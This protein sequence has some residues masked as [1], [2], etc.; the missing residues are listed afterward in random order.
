[1]Q[2][3]LVVG[4]GI[5]GAQVATSMR[6]EGFKGKITIIGEEPF[7]PYERPPLSKLFLTSKDETQLIDCFDSDHYQEN[8]IDLLLGR[9][10]QAVDVT[11]QQVM[12][13]GDE[14]LKY[15]LLVFATGSRAR[16]LNIPGAAAIRTLRTAHD[17]QALR[18]ELEPGQ[19]V[20]CIGAGVIGLELASSACMLGCDVNVITHG[21]DVMNRSLPRNLAGVL[22][23]VHLEQGVNFHFQTEVTQVEKGRLRFRTGATL[24]GDVFIAGVGAERNTELAQAAGIAVRTGIIVDEFG[25]T[26]VPSVYAVGDVAEYFSPRLGKHVTAENWHHAQRH[27]ASVGTGIAGRAVPYDEIPRFWTDQQ[28]I[29]IQVVGNIELGARTIFRGDPDSKRFC[30]FQFDENNIPV[31][32][33]GFDASKD[34]M[35]GARLIERALPTDIHLIAN[36]TVSLKSILK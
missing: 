11:A 35:G 16:R 17:A 31:A 33:I 27:A 12:L 15:T 3:C 19:K 13:L 28:G 14:V 2:T 26:N 18:P 8:Q 36:E 25:R 4:A 1:M 24:D 6:Q 32:V 29:N 34:V 20:I 23:K 9:K 21:K 10:V 30:A 22:K 7:A 5:A